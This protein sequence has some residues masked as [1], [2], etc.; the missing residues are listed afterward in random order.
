MRSLAQRSAAAAREI[1]GLIGGSVDK[2]GAGTRLVG[3]AGSTMRATVE[4]VLR[5]QAL[6]GEIAS[7][8]HHES[9]SIGQINGTVTELDRMTQQNA[10]LVEQAAAASASLNAQA[11]R[12]NGLVAAFRL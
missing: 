8:S 12:L 10:A 6:V 2:V 5:L 4:A 11:E 9:D 3:D 7:A 1:K